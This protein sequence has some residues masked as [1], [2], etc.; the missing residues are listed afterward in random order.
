MKKS[1]IFILSI[2]FVSQTSFSMTRQEYLNGMFEAPI[3]RRDQTRRVNTKKADSLASTLRTLKSLKRKIRDAANK[4]NIDPMHIAG[5][6]AGEHAL[7]VSWVDS[8][9]NTNIQRRMA[10]EWVDQDADNALF[11]EMSL[12]QYNECKAIRN[13]YNFWYCVVN[14]WYQKKHGRV[15]QA[16]TPQNNAYKEFIRT[17]FNPNGIGKTFGL[18]QLSPLRAL[19]VS[20][21]VARATGNRIPR[22]SFRNNG[23]SHQAY[24]DI[25]NDE[26]VVYYTAATIRKSIDAYAEIARFDISR[27]PGVVATL[28]NIGNER[29]HANNRRRENIRNIR[30][31]KS[32]APPTSNSFGRW[33]LQHQDIIRESIR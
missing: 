20:D 21:M 33:V 1:N 19:M 3:V 8:M 6:I 29:F 16:F 24:S 4:F 26:R 30:D 10:N 27:N 12:S 32:I 23:N 22:I 28:Y 14:T 15:I 13:D 7:N 5:A 31:G 25:L 18:G 17:Y 11:H 2:L 9:Q